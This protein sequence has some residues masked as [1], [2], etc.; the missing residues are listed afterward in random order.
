MIPILYPKTATKTDCESGNGLGFLTECLECEVTE[1]RNGEFEAAIKYP[2]SGALFSEIEDGA[3]IKAAANDNAKGQL[4]RI[5][6]TSK[7]LKGVVTYYAEHISYALSDLPITALK[8]TNQ[9][10]QT[11]LMAALAASPISHEFKGYSDITTPNNVN[12]TSPRSLRSTLGGSSGSLL[13]VY[14]GEFEFNNYDVHLWLHRGADNGVILRYGKNITDIKQESVITDCYT[15]IMPF[16]TQTLTNTDETTGETTTSTKTVTLSEQVLELISPAKVG[17]KKALIVDFSEKFSDDEELTE[18]KLRVYAE[19]YIEA[20]DLSTPSVNITV[21]FPALWAAEDYVTASEFESVKL[22]DTVR[23]IFEP[24]GITASAKVIKTVY[25]S[26][27]E[28][29]KSV[30]IGSVKSNFSNTVKTISQS[31]TD[32]SAAAETQYSQLSAKITVNADRITAEATRASNAEGTLAINLNLTADGLSAEIDSRK[33][34]DEKLTNSIKATAEG[35]YEDLK[36]YTTNSE[37]ANELKSYVTSEGLTTTLSNYA[38]STDLNSYALKSSLSVYVTSESLSS[39][40]S[41]YTTNSELAN[42]L[43]SYVTSEG[44]TTTLSN[45]A[46][47]TDLNSYALKSSLSVYVTSESLSSTLSSYTTNSELANELKS[48]VTSEGLTTTLSNYAKSTDLNSYALKSSLSVYV[49][50]ESLSSTLSSYTTN[51]E[52]ATELKS[53]VTSS[54]LTTTISDY[55]KKEGGTASSFSYSL[56]SSAF[57]LKA[58]NS[59]VFKADKDGVTINGGGTFSGSLSAATGTFAGELK[60]ATGTFSGTLSANC[61]S[62]GTIDAS[63]ITVKNL[64]ASNITSGTLSASRIDADNLKVKAANISGT[65][66][67]SQINGDKLSI[68]NGSFSGSIT[69]TSGKIGGWTIGA[70]EIY[71]GV[72]SATDSSHQGIYIGI[73]TIRAGKGVF[74][75]DND[76]NLIA[77]SATITG[78]ITATSGKFS[79]QL[80]AG[81]TASGNMAVSIDGH[82][83]SIF[84]SSGY[85]Y[86]LSIGS[87]KKLYAYPSRCSGTTVYRVTTGEA[88]TSTVYSSGGGSS[89]LP[90]IGG[91]VNP[92]PSVEAL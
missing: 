85:G 2:V 54:S 83:I 19:A 82:G 91:N 22:C 60:A 66:S 90:S 41:S 25:N 28:Q 48:Y 52:L 84:N 77:S 75:L 30:E 27:T 17:H 3:I 8:V 31:V 23:V 43:K 42:E 55:A 7:P 38:K 53:Y 67:A 32:L 78:A 80:Y 46:K 16:A 11:A 14:G 4:F 58:N 34:G 87:D 56:T 20:N 35:I 70:N 59:T 26:L 49:T 29:Y 33:S 21:S 74:N 79:G 76:G 10:A 37:L 39:T 51:S 81:S 36:S 88:L 44:L 86:T 68:A 24:L 13:D 72:T 40:L 65:L 71:Y 69:A 63:N 57:E 12:I 61:L 47:S 62:G 92:F 64:N 9:T 18:E 89:G 5:Y 45:Y 73:G 6:K 50:S 15:H 1:E